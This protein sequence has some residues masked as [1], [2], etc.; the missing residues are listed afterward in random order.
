MYFKNLKMLRKERELTQAQVAQVL[1]CQREVY[2]RYESG[3]SELPI[4]YA[5]ILADF[6]GVS[7]GKLLE[8]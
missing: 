8:I 6:Y 5:F 1:Y 2:R 4:S 3:Q 7:L